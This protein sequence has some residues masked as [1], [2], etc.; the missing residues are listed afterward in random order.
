M[1][2]MFFG[3]VHGEFTK[4]RSLLQK[5]STQFPDCQFY[6][7]GDLVDRGPSSKDVVQLCIDSG[8]R[9]VMGNHDLWVCTLLGGQ[10][11]YGGVKFITSR[12]M[13]GKA[14]LESYGVDVNTPDDVIGSVLRHAMPD[15]HK[16]F[17][18]EMPRWRVIHHAG[19]V[20]RVTHGGIDSHLGGSVEQIIKSSWAQIGSG[21]GNNCSSPQDVI[22]DVATSPQFDDEIMWIGAKPP[23][24]Y[25]FDDG[26]IQVFGHTPIG[27]SP[28]VIPER[29]YI[30]LDTGCGTCPPYAL[31]GVVVTDEG[32]YHPFVV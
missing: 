24:V 3:D 11:F 6:S 31:S 16:L 13:G 28:L 20:Y 1:S 26:S 7:T 8:V 2:V 14:T 15:D 4:L 5:V 22:F 17:F 32:G 18:H 30:A 25:Q 10:P 19:C 29:G 9:P 23:K 12:V 27:K 21:V